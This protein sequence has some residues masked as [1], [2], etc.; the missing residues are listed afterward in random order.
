M[1]LTI[2]TQHNP[3]SDLSYLLHK[4]PDKFQSIKL[5]IGKAHV[6]YPESN[7]D[8]VTVALLLDVDP[9]DLVKG[10]KNRS[11]RE[12]TLGQY[13][14]DRPYVSSSFMSVALSKAF[15]TAMNGTCNAKPELVDI[16][17]DFKVKMSVVSASKG[18]EILIRNLFE[19]LGYNVDLERHPLDE[20]FESWGD[21]K[22][23][24]V[25]LQN[26][27]KLKDLLS[28][29]Y[30]MLPVLDNDKH[31]YVNQDE[32]NKLLDK[33]KGWLETHPEKEQITKRYLINLKSLT[34]QAL[35]LLSEEKLVSEGDIVEESTEEKKK[36][37]S[38]HDKRLDFVLEKAIELGAKK[39]VDLGSG[40]GKLIRRLLKSKQFENILGMDV[41]YSELLKAKDRLHYNDMPPKQKERLELIQGSLIYRDDRLRGYDLATV[42]EVIEHMELNKLPAFERVLFEFAR[43]KAVILT[44]PNSEYNKTF[45]KM[46]EGTLRHHDHRFEWNREEF[47]AWAE[48]VAAKYKYKLEILPVGDV[49]EEF[50]AP[51]QMGIF[52]L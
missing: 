36:F 34:R 44:T 52:R 26:K 37:E 5:S 30:V 1:I 32:I 9:I 15:S 6:Y 19:P 3:G 27:L 25:E 11:I 23:F 20:K 48:N 18:G 28:H 40:E 49:H 4:H 51:T 17:M 8:K 16:E 24:T 13:V 33:G 29:L 50:G 39:V 46:D 12:F 38:L 41:S 22:Y 14:N 2:T 10:V 31:Y 7:D 35:D 45:E 47:K 42:I 21:S 43:P